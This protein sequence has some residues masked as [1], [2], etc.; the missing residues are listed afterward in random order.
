MALEQ[1]PHARRLRRQARAELGER[2]QRD[3]AHR[4]RRLGAP[5]RALDEADDVALAERQRLLAVEQAAGRAAGGRQRLAKL[6]DRPQRPQQQRRLGVGVGGACAACTETAAACTA[7]R[8]SAARTGATTTTAAAAAAAAARAQQRARRDARRVRV[9]VRRVRDE[10]DERAH[11]ALLDA[12]AGRAHDRDKLVEAPARVGR[13]A[14]HQGGE[15]GGEVG[16]ELGVARAEV[17]Q[18][19]A[20]ERLD[21]G[22]VDERVDELERAPPDRRVGVAHALDDGRAVALHRGAVGGDDLGERVERDAADVVVAVREEAAE[23][24]DRHHA[25]PADRLDAHDRVDGL[26][27]HRVAGVARA[28]DV[29]R[30]LR[31]RVGHRVARVGAAAAE[32]AQQLQQLDLQEGVV[33]A[34]DVVLGR[35]AALQQRPQQAAERG[36]VRAVA[37]RGAR[38]EVADRE[39]ERGAREQHAVVLVVQEVGGAVG[40]LLDELG[41]LLE[42]AVVLDARGWRGMGCG[43]G[44]GCCGVSLECVSPDSA[45]RDPERSRARALPRAAHA[46]DRAERRLLADVRVA[47]VAQQALDVGREVARHL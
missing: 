35:A 34:G 45:S 40:K 11:R 44:G 41:V 18:Q 46:P 31:E 30:D 15:L 24:V 12:R 36:H 19:L 21:V 1:R 9:Q 47:G 27:E 43:W 2:R 26:V 32:R 38:V 13:E 7:A 39:H 3:L 17:L 16:P 23:D 37:L 4:G 10:H 42:H 14:R 25:Q 33:H 22:A 5:Q 29:G 8:A 6:A 28:L 20:R